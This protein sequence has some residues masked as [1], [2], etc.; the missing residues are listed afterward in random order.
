MESVRTLKRALRR[1]I[2][3]VTVADPL[4]HLHMVPTMFDTRVKL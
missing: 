1:L 3:L 4:E 2:E